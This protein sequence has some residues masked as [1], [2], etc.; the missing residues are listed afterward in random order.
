MTKLIVA[1]RNVANAPKTLNSR[2]YEF[3][4]SNLFNHEF[5]QVGRHRLWMRTQVMGNANTWSRC[6]ESVR[7]TTCLSSSLTYTDL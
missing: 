6:V 3:K 7:Q 4:I 5:W 2:L 1:F